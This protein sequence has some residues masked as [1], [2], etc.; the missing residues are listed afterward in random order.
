MINEKGKYRATG[1]VSGNGARA[2]G[3]PCGKNELEIGPG[4][5]SHTKVNSRLIQDLDVQGK[6]KL[7]E[8]EN[9]EYLA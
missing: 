8:E 5:T 2:I 7:S 9:R 1:K 6:P 4:F 3:Y